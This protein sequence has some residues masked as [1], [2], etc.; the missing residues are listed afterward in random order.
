MG[1][2]LRSGHD[3]VGGMAGQGARCSLP[4]A[5]AR[6][7]RWPRHSGDGQDALFRVEFG[8]ANLTGVRELGFE[9]VATTIG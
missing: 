7:F 2:Q 1:I 3:A 9:F 6:A 8:A 4:D 5:V